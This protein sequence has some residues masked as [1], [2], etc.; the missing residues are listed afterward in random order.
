[1]SIVV[2]THDRPAQLAT[3]LTSLIEQEYP[4][5]EIIVV[6]NAPSSDDAA[7]LVE[8]MSQKVTRPIIRYLC[9]PSPGLA[10]AH[11]R[12]LEEVR[13]AIVAFTDDDV[14][15]DKQWL[16]ELVKGFTVAANVGCVSGMITALELETPPQCWI[17]E[18]FKFNKGFT[19]TLFDRTT[20]PPGDHFYPFTAGQFGSGANMAFRTSVLRELGGFD[21]ALGAGS[22]ARGGDDLAAFF[23]II[24]A[25]YTLV[26]EPGAIIYHSHAS[27]E[28]LL[29]RQA[30]NYGM[31]FT[32]FLTSAVIHHPTTLPRLLA[33]LPGGIRHFHRLR[34]GEVGNRGS[35]PPELRRLE[36]RGMAAG[37]L[38]YLQ[39]LLR[40][41][42]TGRQPSRGKT[43]LAARG[44]AP[45]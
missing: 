44:T 22:R 18:G 23:A 21:P 7:Q 32:A 30:Y 12:G 24:S 36:W 39:S 3:C 2:A 6:D 28:E 37:P 42:R 8:A 1:V 17:E 27:D 19:R 43:V 26:Y 35:Y 33:R 11:N 38:A 10:L 25:G 41:K 9:E 16:A 40:R 4:D 29:K 14:V 20:S 15:A 34:S 31:G 5:F 13:T 45:H